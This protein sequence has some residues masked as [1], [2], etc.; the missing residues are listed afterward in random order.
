MNFGAC[1]ATHADAELNAHIIFDSNYAISG[2]A[3]VHWNA[4]TNGII[5]V[6]G[7]TITL[8]GTPAFSAAFAWVSGGF[9]YAPINTFSGSATGSRYSVQLNGIISTAGGGANYLPGN[10]AGSTATGGQYG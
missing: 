8:S 2:A 10:S 4:V 3:A 6:I 9:V 5:Q 1:S 7:H